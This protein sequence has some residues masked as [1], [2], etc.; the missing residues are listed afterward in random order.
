MKIQSNKSLHGRSKNSP[1]NL[2]REIG[3]KKEVGGRVTGTPKKGGAGEV[4][5]EHL[6]DRE[7]CS[8]DL[9]TERETK[10]GGAGENPAKKNGK[11]RNKMQKT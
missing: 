5:I 3:E 10:F 8:Q 6:N 11:V 1:S 2:K 7:Q 4:L 9:G